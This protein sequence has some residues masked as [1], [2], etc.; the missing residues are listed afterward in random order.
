[1]TF[2]EQIYA[3]LIGTACGAVLGFIF[4]VIG[5]RINE[6]SK[7]KSELLNI[8]NN[9]KYE[10]EIN[11]VILFGRVNEINDYIKTIEDNDIFSFSVFKKYERI[12]LMNS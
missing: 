5:F 1:M 9:L 7:S 12:I 8:I 4:A 6:K 10:F 11:Q 3:T 2:E